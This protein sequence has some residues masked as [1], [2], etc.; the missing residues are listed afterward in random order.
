MVVDLDRPVI[1]DCRV[2]QDRWYTHEYSFE[3]Q[4]GFLLQ[5]IAAAHADFYFDVSPTELVCIELMCYELN[6]E[7]RFTS[8]KHEEIYLAGGFPW[9]EAPHYLVESRGELFGLSSVRCIIIGVFLLLL[10][11]YYSSLVLS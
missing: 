10:Y 6:P 9:E 4:P 3:K 5:S 2:T 11:I 8:T 7:P 1:W